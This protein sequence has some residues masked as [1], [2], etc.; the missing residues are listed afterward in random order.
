MGRHTQFAHS[1]K[2]IF[3]D[4]LRMAVFTAL[5]FCLTEIG[6]NLMNHFI[7]PTALFRLSVI[8]PLTSRDSLDHGEFKKIVRELSAKTYDIP[9]S[10]RVHIDGKTIERWFY[11]WRKQGIDGLNPKSRSDKGASQLPKDIQQK[12]LALKKEN[13][14]RSLNTLIQLLEM[15]GHVQKNQIARATIHRFLKSHGLSKPIDEFG[16]TIERRAFEALFAGDIWYGDVMHGPCIQTDK[17]VKKTYLVSIMDDASRLICHSAFCL[18]ETALS[19]EFILKEA[20]LKRGMP[21]KLVI[22]NGSA[23]RSQSLQSICARLNIQIVYC[24]PYEPEGKGK[25]ERFHRTFRDQFLTEINIKDIQCLNDLN[26]R[27]WVWIEKIYHQTSHSALQ[28]RQTPLMRFQ[29][30]LIK[31]KSLGRFAENLDQYFY[32]RIKRRVKKDGTISY[33]GGLYEVSFNLVNQDVL[34]V[35]DPHQQEPKWIESLEYKKISDVFILDKHLNNQRIRHRS[36][37]NNETENEKPNT[38]PK[39]SLIEIAFDSQKKALGITT[40]A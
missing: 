7:H 35:F 36:K 1:T 13:S 4:L 32:H 5:I 38:T 24:R 6:E 12:L 3:C 37:I 34:L 26:A 8:G 30:D 17:G 11:Q 10:K 2:M 39:T 28:D 19:I 25:L 33:E 21:K 15:Q 9:N 27:L 18:D 23:Y 16:T 31:I 29:K 20:L 14:K 40:D 22:D